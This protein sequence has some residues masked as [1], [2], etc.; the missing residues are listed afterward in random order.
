MLRRI[1]LKHPIFHLLTISA[2]KY[3]VDNGFLFKCKKGNNIYKED[4]PARANIYFVLYGQIE[5]RSTKISPA[6]RFG[7]TI[8]L[9]WT[10]GEEILYAPESE[11]IFRKEACM[12]IN[13]SCMLQVN[14]EDLV[15]MS[16]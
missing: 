2:F 7:E 1:R 5:F 15:T 16:S 4:Q 11:Q 3:M 8:S 12:S 10:L 6:G 13:D 9:G 14:V